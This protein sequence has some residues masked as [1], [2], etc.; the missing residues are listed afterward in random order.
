MF[1]RILFPVDFSDQS[2]L[3]APFVRVMAE[4]EG[5]EV[6]LLHV[7]GR[8]PGKTCPDSKPAPPEEHAHFVDRLRHFGRKF[9]GPDSDE[10]K[11]FWNTAVETGRPGERIVAYAAA[12]QT[13]LIMIGSFGHGEYIPNIL[14]HEAVRTLNEAPCPV[15]VTGHAEHTN[16]RPPRPQPET[17]L[18]ALDLGPSSS[19][20]LHFTRSFSEEWHVRPTLIHSVSMPM[21]VPMTRFDY[22]YRDYLIGRGQAGL[23]R[24][25]HEAGTDYPVCIAPGEIAGLIRGSVLRQE[26]DLLIMGRG[27][28]RDSRGRLNSH[29]LSIIRECPCPVLTV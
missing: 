18:T 29:S 16:C 26:A 13:D 7:I 9:L 1:Q 27:K 28:T 23:K 10:E 12:N 5:A 24:L 2:R 3:I 19:C 14:G 11:P 22:E 6:T 20:L 17:V 25:Q 15:W 21:A 4:H 8:T